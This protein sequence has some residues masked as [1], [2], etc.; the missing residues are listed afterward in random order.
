MGCRILFGRAAEA[1]SRLG[2]PSDIL[3][4]LQSEENM[5]N[6]EINH[7][8]TGRASS[9]NRLCCGEIAIAERLNG[10]LAARILDMKECTKIQA[11]G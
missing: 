7:E 10:L 3:T 11:Y 1:I 6:H 9:C 4:L 2:N 5:M 8:A